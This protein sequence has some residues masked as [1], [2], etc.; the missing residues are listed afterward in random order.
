MGDPIPGNQLLA[1]LDQMDRNGGLPHTILYSLNDRFCNQMA[2][3]AG[4]FSR[5]QCGTAWWFCDHRRGIEEQIHNLAEHSHLGSFLGMLTDS[6][7]F[8]SY[9]RHDYF[10]RIFCDV[11][12]RLVEEEGFPAASAEKIVARVCYQNSKNMVL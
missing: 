9:A 7:S 4:C 6:R 12:G 10:R 8:L 3:I 1:L 2:V 11:I 5:V